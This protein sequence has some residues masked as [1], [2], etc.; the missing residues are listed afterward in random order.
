MN[1]YKKDKQ[2]VNREIHVYSNL[3]NKETSVYKFKY[4]YTFPEARKY[5]WQQKMEAINK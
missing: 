1:K 4:G 3:E 5:Y 2:K